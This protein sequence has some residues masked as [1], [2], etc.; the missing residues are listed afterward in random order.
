MKAPPPVVD[1]RPHPVALADERQDRLVVAVPV[2]EFDDQRQNGRVAVAVE[3]DEPL[4][5][6]RK[7]R[8]PDKHN[9]QADHQKG[10]GTLHDKDTVSKEGTVDDKESGDGY[11]HDTSQEGAT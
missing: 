10:E 9:D 11:D 3:L 6:T 1:D 7:R 5:A 4:Q 2:L 8:H